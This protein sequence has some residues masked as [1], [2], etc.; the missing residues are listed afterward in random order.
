MRSRC[1]DS[2][3]GPTDA[4]VLTLLEGEV[5]LLSD[6]A[7]RAR[8]LSSCN[9][10]ATTPATERLFPRA[11]LDPTEEEAETEWQSLVHD[12]LVREQGRRARRRSTRRSNG[13][14]PGPDGSRQFDARRAE[15]GAAPAAVLNDARLA[16]AD[17]RGRHRRDDRSDSMTRRRGRPDPRRRALR[18]AAAPGRGPDRPQARRPP[19]LAISAISW[20]PDAPILGASRGPFGRVGGLAFHEHAAVDRADRRGPRATPGR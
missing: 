19:R 10:T 12:D 1:I 17:R 8:A 7:G 13:A 18:V 5:A 15:R 20:R 3:G 4:L 9:P 11:Y 14:S 2:S 16:F 6:V